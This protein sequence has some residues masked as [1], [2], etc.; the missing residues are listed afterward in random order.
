MASHDLSS[1]NH[2][3]YDCDGRHHDGATLTH[4]IGWDH[5]HD[6]NGHCYVFEHGHLAAF[7]PQQCAWPRLVA[8][9]VTEPDPRLV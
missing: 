8:L 1:H 3:G 2:E 7:D 9:G 4:D 6:G 5:I